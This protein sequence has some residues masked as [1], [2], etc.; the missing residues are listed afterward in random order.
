[1]DAGRL[2]ECTHCGTMNERWQ[3]DRTGMVVHVWFYEPGSWQVEC[4]RCGRPFMASSPVPGPDG[5]VEIRD[6]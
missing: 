5:E 6:E 1:M 4:C 2:E 3:W